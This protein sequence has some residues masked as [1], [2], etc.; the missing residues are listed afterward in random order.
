MM[1]KAGTARTAAPALPA[2]VQRG[3]QW[4][5][6]ILSNTTSD[7]QN[8]LRDKLMMYGLDKWTGSTAGVQEL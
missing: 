2:D 5:L 7:T 8:I 1:T 4:M 6:F 3:E